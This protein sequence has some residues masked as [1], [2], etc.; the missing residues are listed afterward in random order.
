MHP[1]DSRRAEQ[2]PAAAARAPDRLS[3]WLVET[4]IPAWVARAWHPGLQGY[5]ER[6]SWPDGAVVEAARRSTMVTAR[7]VYTFSLCHVLGAAAP[8]LAAAA[9]GV[10]MLVGACRLPDGGFAHSLAADGSV[11]DAQGDLYDLAFVLLGLGGYVAASGRRD[12][13]E[14]AEAIGTRLDLDHAD[15]RGGYREPGAAGGPRRQFPQMHLFEA[16]QLLARLSPDRGWEGRAAAILD[17]LEHRLVRAD[18]GIDEWYDADWRPVRGD[19][20]VERELGHQFEWAWLL[21]RHS[22]SAGVLRARLLADQVYDCGRAAMRRAAIGPLPNR[23]DAAGRPL[24]AARPM[25][26]LAELLRASVAAGIAGRGG[27]SAE[28][29]AASLQALF[30]HHID[31]QSGLWI[32]D[33]GPGANRAERVVPARVLYHLVPAFAALARERESAFNMRSPILDRYDDPPKNRTGAAT[34]E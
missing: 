34:G 9:H 7:L 6:V 16:F 29:A 11:A 14:T 13:L 27:D 18:G 10:E 21:Y 31:R 25:W 1:E 8:C 4:F 20:A 5:A 22:W 12:L 30:A 32:N 17:L 24:D 33:L 2:L 19:H 3:A 15:R 23:I 28:I 26:P